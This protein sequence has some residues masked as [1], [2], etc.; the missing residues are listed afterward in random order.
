[1]L[2]V[3][4]KILALIYEHRWRIEVFFRALKHLL[5]CRH[6]RSHHPDGIKIQTYCAIIAC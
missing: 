2:D 5:G 6:P 3:P 4:V 1:M